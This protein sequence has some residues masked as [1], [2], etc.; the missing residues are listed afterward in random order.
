MLDRLRSALSRLN[1]S[2]F[3]KRLWRRWDMRILQKSGLF[4][5]EFYKER[6][7]DVA[8]SGMDPAAHYLSSGAEEGR[9]PNPFF[10]THYYWE[11]NPD[12]KR[13][14]LNPL[15]HYILQGAKEGRQPGPKFDG[16][17]KERSPASPARSAKNLNLVERVKSMHSPLDNQRRI[18]IVDC[19]LPT[20]DLDAGSVRM[21]MLTRMFIGLGIAVTF[22]SDAVTVQPTYEDELVRMGVQVLYGLPSTALHLER[23]GTRYRW[24]WLARPKTAERYMATARAYAVFAQVIYDTVDLHWLRFQRGFEVTGDPAL[25]E[26]AEEH[27]KVEA[28]CITSADLVIA[29]SDTEKHMI[30]TE[31]PDV[32]VAVLTTIYNCRPLPSAWSERQGLLFI[33]SYWHAPNL[34]AITWFTS[35][36]MPRILCELPDVCFTILGSN[37]PDSFKA[38]AS[39]SIKPVGYVRDV[40]PYF[41]A[42]RV[43]VAPLRYGA[44]MKG[45]LGQSMSLGLPVVTTSIGAEGMF[46]QDGVQALIADSAPEFAAAVV[47]LYRNEKLWTELRNAALS[48]LNRCFSEEAAQHALRQVLQ[49]DAGPDTSPASVS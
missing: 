46:L 2:K 22:V 14:G 27:K 31:F 11:H 20:P 30:L 24:V 38:L 32:N 25:A 5:R 8:R 48:H 40:E 12:V 45:K 34:D 13:A 44:G 6:Y 9:D 33:G 15:L 43:F 35:E 42:A 4:D 10:S 49:L 36:V 23:E 26:C 39:P 41:D 17:G 3:R 47:K 7:P 1:T 28:F 18:L 29:I 21:H 37:A 16:Q 19:N